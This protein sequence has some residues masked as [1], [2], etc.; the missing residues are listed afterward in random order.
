MQPGDFYVPFTFSASIISTPPVPQDPIIPDSTHPSTHQQFSASA[1][2]TSPVPQDPIT[3][4]TTHPTQQQF[5]AHDLYEQVYDYNTTISSNES[6][7]SSIY[8]QVDCN[9]QRDMIGIDV[10]GHVIP[11]YFD[12]GEV[13]D[14]MALIDQVSDFYSP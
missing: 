12:Y 9:P 14:S 11:A 1:I 2:S 6:Q 4:K 5:S 8:E 13:T 10:V 7:H 3:L